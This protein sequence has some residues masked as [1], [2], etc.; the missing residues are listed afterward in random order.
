MADMRP[1]GLG[2]EAQGTWE[3]EGHEGSAGP[4]GRPPPLGPPEQ[5]SPRHTLESDTRLA[6]CCLRAHVSGV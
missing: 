1:R 2:T 3:S 4:Q 5:A 6:P